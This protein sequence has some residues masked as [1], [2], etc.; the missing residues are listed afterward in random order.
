MR[1]ELCMGVNERD[2]RID[3]TYGKSDMDTNAEKKENR[4]KL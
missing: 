4:W 3:V 2:E 1:D